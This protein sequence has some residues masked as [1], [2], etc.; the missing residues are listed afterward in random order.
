MSWPTKEDLDTLKAMPTEILLR[1]FFLQVR[2]IWRV[3]GLYF[4]GVEERLGTD[5]ATEIDANCWRVMGRIEAR[6]LKQELGVKRNDVAALMQT[7]RS[8]SW[9]LYQTGKEAVGSN[10]SGI[11]RV[12]RCRTQETRLKKGLGEFPC[13]RVRFAYLKSFAEAFNP[14]IEVEC[15][16]CP[17]GPHPENTWCE[18]AFTL[19]K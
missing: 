17:P 3:D 5:E 11:F 8:T 18:W 1:L 9:A 13:R 19:R 10:D 6:E 2:N 15:K 12:S 7:L 14:N 4:L 16:T